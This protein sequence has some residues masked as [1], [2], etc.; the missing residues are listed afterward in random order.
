M[1]TWQEF[2]GNSS[3]TPSAVRLGSNRTSLTTPALS[4]SFKHTPTFTPESVFV[5]RVL[6]PSVDDHGSPVI[7][8][9]VSVRPKHL[10]DQNFDHDYYFNLPLARERDAH[11]FGRRSSSRHVPLSGFPAC[12]P[13]FT[14]FTYSQPFRHIQYSRTASLRAMATVAMFLCRRSTRCI[15]RRLPSESQRA[16]A[17]PASPSKK[18]SKEPPCLVMW[19]R[20]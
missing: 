18:R 12:G 20:R 11:S 19:P 7:L 6:G 16:A 3:P 10:F 15:Y 4:R 5:H 8:R 14:H 2:W 13:N 1:D 9:S 17:W